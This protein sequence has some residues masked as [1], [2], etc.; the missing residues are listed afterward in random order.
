M[1]KNTKKAKTTNK[2]EGTVPISGLLKYLEWGDH[3]VRE[4]LSIP[5]D[6]EYVD[7]LGDR[8][9]LAEALGMGV[10]K[11]ICREGG[12]L[13]TAAATALH[14]LLFLPRDASDWRMRHSAVIPQQRIAEFFSRTR[15]WQVYLDSLS[16]VLFMWC[17]RGSQLGS[18]PVVLSQS[19]RTA[20]K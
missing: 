7:L 18:A 8:K 5:E 13:V 14:G 16:I 3:S 12:K 1:S 6:A 20:T 4:L 19:W 9:S 17:C 11:I 15:R 10:G 2:I